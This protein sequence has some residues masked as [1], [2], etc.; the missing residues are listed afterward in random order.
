MQS[1]DA[2]LQSA[3][4]EFHVAGIITIDN[5]AGAIASSGVSIHFAD[6]LRSTLEKPALALANAL[7]AEG[8]TIA[9]VFRDTADAEKDKDRTRI[10]VMIG[11]K[12]VN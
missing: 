5:K 1:V 2:S 11:S 12:P 7:V 10:H 4:W 8:I 6:E 3:K 9:G